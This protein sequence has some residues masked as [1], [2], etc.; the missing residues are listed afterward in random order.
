MPVRTPV[1]FDGEIDGRPRKLLAQASRNG[2]F[3][4]LDRATGERVVSTEFVKTNWTLGVDAEGAADS[5]SGSARRAMGRW[6]RRIRVE[7]LTG[8]LRVSIRRLVCF[9]PMQGARASVYYLYD[10]SDE[11]GGL[12]RRS[13]RLFGGDAA[14][15][16]LQD[17]Q[18]ESGVINGRA[19]GAA[20]GQAIEYGGKA[21]VRR[22]IRVG[23]L[24]RSIRLAGGGFVAYGFGGEYSEWAYDL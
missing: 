9:T 15:D 10:D 8:R 12:G 21:A 4:V 3:F 7:R 23:I 13:W 11:A 14:G 5:E 16:R 19:V 2:W 6:F 24:W 1:L 20:C 22:A 17:R 18:S